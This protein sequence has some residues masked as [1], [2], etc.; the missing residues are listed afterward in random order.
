MEVER[1]LSEWLVTI[2]LSATMMIFVVAVTFVV[3]TLVAAVVV[4][5]V[6]VVLVVGARL[7]RIIASHPAAAG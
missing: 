2:C 1:L 7:H 3:V 6:V 5:A 4:V